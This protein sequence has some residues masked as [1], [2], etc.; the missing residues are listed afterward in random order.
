MPV[1]FLGYATQKTYWIDVL[2]SLRGLTSVL[3]LGMTVLLYR[4]FQGTYNPYNTQKMHGKVILLTGGTS[5][6]GASVARDLAGRG[7][8]LILLVRSVSDGWTQDYI[9]DL[10][11]QTGNA[12]IYAEECDLESLHSVRKFATKWIDNSPPRRLDQVILCAGVTGPM[13]G[14]RKVTTGDRVEQHL[15]VNYLANFLLLTILSPALRAQPSERDVRVIVATCTSYILARVSLTDLEFLDRGYPSTRPWHALGASKLY[16][17]AF[18]RQLQCRIDAYARPDGL[19]SRVKCLTIDPGLART[20]SFRSFV[21]CGTVIGLVVYML[22]YPFWF[23]C[24][25]S[26]DAAAQ[27]VLYASMAP[28]KDVTGEGV[29]AGDVVQECRSK[30]I[31]RTE[32]TDK[33]FQLALWD[34]SEAMI[35]E[36]ETRSA[37]ARKA[38]EKEASRKTK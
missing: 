34:A 4:F 8:Q 25:K 32:I 30:P 10:R 16:L 36:V 27:S 33:A 2:L 31:R 9:T 6:I 21:S 15:G 29:S 12:L 38:A 17:M 18:L 23:M 7:A 35:K 3:A 13:Y 19:P 37:S 26:A 24:I 5:G 14:V 20:Q 1:E 22:T 11:A 28:S